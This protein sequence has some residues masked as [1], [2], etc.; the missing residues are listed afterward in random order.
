MSCSTAFLAVEIDETF[1][2]QLYATASALASSPS[3]MLGVPD[4]AFE[5]HARNRL[6]MTFVFCDNMLPRL[7][8][9]NL[10]ALHGKINDTIQGVAD[11][12][13]LSFKFA[14]FELFPPDKMNLI[15]AR[16]QASEQLHS[17]R[18]LLWETCVEFGVAKKDDGEWMPHVTLGK[19]RATRA[20]VGLVSCRSLPTLIPSSA[21]RP[22]GLSLLGAIPKQCNLNWKEAF[23]FGDAAEGAEL[24]AAVPSESEQDALAVPEMPEDT[25]LEARKRVEHYMKAKDWPRMVA[26]LRD[27]LQM[28]PHWIKGH[29][30]LRQA[31][32]NCDDSSGA[33]CAMWAAFHN[34]PEVLEF[35]ALLGKVN[36]A[37]SVGGDLTQL[38][39][40]LQERSAE[41]KEWVLS[42]M[43]KSKASQRA[44]CWDPCAA[45]D[46]GSQDAIGAALMLYKSTISGHLVLRPRQPLRLIFLDVDGVL[47]TSSKNSGDLCPVLLS[48]LRGVMA[49]TGAFVILSSTWRNWSELR[50]LIMA[51]LPTGSVIGQT[52]LEDAS[53]WVNC[54][55]PREIRDFLVRA[56]VEL[57]PVISWAAVDDM[58]LVGQANDL[59]KH[60]SSMKS[61]IPL[62][63]SHFV[64]TCEHTGL[65]D[66]KSSILSK[67]LL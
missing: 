34:A 8:K 48:N 33:L 30:C 18:K 2:A 6:H 66:E 46:V 7:S 17:L 50:V 57:G 59:A 35:K 60:D 11:S 16:F 55:R 32:L 5:P 45:L 52:P 62:I 42:L 61:F 51:A 27:C 41:L 19:L 25:R 37:A 39:I 53:S 15:I 21:C 38:S 31:L 9:D 56:E 4:I 29:F 64:H 13:L 54:V 36:A 23:A 22:L 24:S 44:S 65:D 63:E 1:R 47:N 49:T 3:Q 43:P 26:E 40:E 14:G 58:N 20:Q 10:I 28:E 12:D 67:M